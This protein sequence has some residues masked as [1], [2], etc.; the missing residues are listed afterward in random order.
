MDYFY[1]LPTGIAL[2]LIYLGVKAN[3]RVRARLE[4]EIRDNYAGAGA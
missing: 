2:I 3:A 1:M 4:Q